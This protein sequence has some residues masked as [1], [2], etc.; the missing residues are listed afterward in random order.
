MI[1]SLI[2]MAGL[3]AH[4]AP[5]MGKCAVSKLWGTTVPTIPM[6]QERHL[7]FAQGKLLYWNSR[8]MTVERAV[9]EIGPEMANGGDI[10][11]IDA[12][13]GKCAVVQQ[14]AAALE[15]P[16]ACT[17]ERCFVSSVPVPARKAP[18]EPA[19]P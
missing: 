18:E 5:M 10:L 11:V 3:G 6:E 19:K 1:A 15:G 2:L 9:A 16:A 12:S 13:A 17:P 4:P 8:L 7:V 14:L